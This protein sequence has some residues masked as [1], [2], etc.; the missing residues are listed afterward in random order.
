M[1][2]ISRST[3]LVTMV[4]VGI[5]SAWGM[6]QR[7]RGN[8]PTFLGSADADIASAGVSGVEPPL[9]SLMRTDVKS[10]CTS[11]KRTTACAMPGSTALQPLAALDDV[12]NPPSLPFLCMCDS[13]S[14]N[15]GHTATRRVA[16]AVERAAREQAEGEAAALRQA[17]QDRR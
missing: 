1:A 10:A 2:A 16:T 11:C 4:S 13:M 15:C 12:H 5:V 9:A 6:D 7:Y 8:G 17:E 3:V 14:T